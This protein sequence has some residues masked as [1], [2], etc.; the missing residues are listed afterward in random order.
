MPEDVDTA[1]MLIKLYTQTGEYEKAAAL[2][3]KF[4]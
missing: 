3:A 4:K 1:N 2:K